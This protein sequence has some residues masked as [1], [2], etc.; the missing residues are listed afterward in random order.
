MLIRF[1]RIAIPFLLLVASLSIYLGF[2]RPKASENKERF[3]FLEETSQNL[4]DYL[5]DKGLAP[6]TATLDSLISYEEQLNIEL[7]KMMMHP[8]LDEDLGDDLESIFS[9]WGFGPNDSIF[10]M[11]NKFHD[12]VSKIMSQENPEGAQTFTKCLAISLCRAGLSALVRLDCLPLEMETAAHGEDPLGMFDVDIVFIAGLTEA[13]Q[14]LEEWILYSGGGVLLKPVK[15][16]IKRV[17][18]RQWNENLRNYSSPPV[19]VTLRVQ[20][21]YTIDKG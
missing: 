9:E 7:E 20:V 17:E 14:F 4:I 16:I 10:L 21:V 6:T 3:V 2:V 15:F 12:L 13:V 1:M 11:V 5:S 18:P 8:S 19:Q